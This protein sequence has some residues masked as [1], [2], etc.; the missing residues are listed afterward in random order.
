LVKAAWLGSGDETDLQKNVVFTGCR[1][2]LRKKYFAPS[3]LQAE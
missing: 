1:K 2:K 3:G